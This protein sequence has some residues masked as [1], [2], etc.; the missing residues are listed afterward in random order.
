VAEP[1]PRPSPPSRIPAFLAPLADRNFGTLLSG[2]FVSSLGTWTQDVALG[3]LIKTRFDNPVYLGLRSFASDAPLIAFMLVGGAAADRFDRRRILLSSQFVQ[4]TTAALLAVLYFTN[5]LGLAPILALAFITGLAQSQ[6]APTYQA[7]L[8]SLVPAQQIPN[9]VALNS[10][11]FN[12]SR[13]IGPVV[14]GLLLVRA[15][16]GACFV[17]NA[18]SFLAIILALWR[19]EIPSP[20]SR[21]G[22][23]EG[24]MAGF[25][26]VYTSPLLL[27]LTVMA[28][29]VSFLT[30]PIITYL[31][32]VA[33]EVLHTGASG[34]ASLL[35]SFG[36]GAI[37]GALST[38]RRGHV[39][40]RGRLILR[41]WI[42]YGLGILGMLFCGRQWMALGFLFVS[43]WM[44]VTAGSTLISLVQENVPDQMR[45]RTLSI[46]NVA[47]RGGM[48]VGA[49]CAGFLVKSLGAVAALSG[50]TV[51]LL[52][53]GVV[54]YW[55]S[56]RLR[57]L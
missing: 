29:A 45:G 55:R 52:L 31:P 38:A 21:Q 24:M 11:Q 23:R 7:T 10:F 54:L 53:M 12:L 8:T 34:Y 18:L 56:S 50:L 6:S 4:M 49:M 48:P 30:Y 51:A 43:G 1:S 40:G 16:E 41:A 27:L 32:V 14:G 19:I 25:R 33:A 44:L 3:W 26:H 2:A 57:T 39:P 15:G 35:S 20:R 47:F 46:F 5:R 37:G 36:L 42:V 9:A 13:F 28:A 22:L 17:L